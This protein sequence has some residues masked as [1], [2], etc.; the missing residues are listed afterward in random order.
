M[1]FVFNGIFDVINDLMH[2][3]DIKH[4]TIFSAENFFAADIQDIKILEA[5]NLS[6]RMHCTSFS[7]PEKANIISL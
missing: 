6:L 1:L 2:F 3:S 4:Y 5:L 7:I